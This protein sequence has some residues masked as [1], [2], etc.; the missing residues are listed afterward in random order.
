[1]IFIRWV[2]EFPDTIFL[3]K[4]KWSKRKS[5][6]QKNLFLQIY[7]NSEKSY[8]HFTKHIVSQLWISLS[9]SKYSYSLNIYYDSEKNPYIFYKIRMNR[10]VLQTYFHD[11]FI[12]YLN[13][14]PRSRDHCDNCIQFPIRRNEINV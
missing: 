6:R 9:F 14:H 8:F 5:L 11:S 13:L 7:H 4:K 1:M 10:V 3:K 2:N 12:T